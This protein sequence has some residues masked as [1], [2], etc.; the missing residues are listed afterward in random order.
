MTEVKSHAKA[1][2][3]QLTTE[4]EPYLTELSRAAADGSTAPAALNRAIGSYQ[5]ALK[6]STDIRRDLKQALMELRA[7]EELM[8]T[9]SVRVPK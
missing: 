1:Y 9:P 3:Q 6:R 5:A 8:N 4:F 7:H 2:L